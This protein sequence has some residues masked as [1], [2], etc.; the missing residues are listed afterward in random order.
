MKCTKQDLCKKSLPQRSDTARFYFR[1]DSDYKER[2]GVSQVREVAFEPSGLADVSFNKVSLLPSRRCCHTSIRT[3]DERSF[4]ARC[5]LGVLV[6]AG[7]ATYRST[8]RSSS[9]KEVGPGVRRSHRLKRS[10]GRVETGFPIGGLFHPT[11]V[12]RDHRRTCRRRVA[13][14]WRERDVGLRLISSHTL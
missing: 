10:P 1:I 4:F 11:R 9:K 2:F 7:A 6:S 5:R 14:R 12:S 13:F 3:L 8:S